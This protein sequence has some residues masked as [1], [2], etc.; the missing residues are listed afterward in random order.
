[1]FFRKKKSTDQN[2]AASRPSVDTPKS[3][4]G[5]GKSKIV[6]PERQSETN[7]AGATLKSTKPP[8]ATKS[9]SKFVPSVNSSHAADIMTALGGIVSV[10][11]RTKQFRTLTLG[12][13]EALV[14]PAL[15][16]NQFAIAST[17][18]NA[19][20][21]VSPAAIA[22]WAQVSNEVDQRLS[23]NLDQRF[24]LAPNEWRSGDIPWLVATA[25]DPR[26]V[27]VILKQ[28]QENRL[29]G[30]SFKMRGKRQDGKEVVGNLAPRNAQAITQK[31]GGQ[32]PR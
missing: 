2:A 28:L 15:L 30:K 17:S 21:L 10:L 11:M 29:K 22:L 24:Q 14:V 27:D 3:G 19:N 13:L 9:S 20:G 6:A 7:A 23:K 1:M 31:A 4:S 25:G 32:A 8:P 12:D 5:A 16:S 26:G 18:A